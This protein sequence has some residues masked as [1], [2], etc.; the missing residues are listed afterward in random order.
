M[1][2]GGLVGRDGVKREK[3]T[4]QGRLNGL[5]EKIG[6][7]KEGLRH[8]LEVSIPLKGQKVGGVQVK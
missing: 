5:C 6:K 1:G 3:N 8:T 2:G 7:G 4:S